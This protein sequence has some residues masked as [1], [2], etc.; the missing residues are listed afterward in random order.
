M[1]TTQIKHLLESAY[2]DFHQHRYRDKDPVMLAHAY[3][4]PEDREVAAFLAACLS[5][6]NVKTILT[7]ATRVLAVLGKSPQKALAQ[8]AFRGKFDG[9]THR[10]TKGS[11]I[12]N[13]CEWLAG[14]LEEHGS[15]HTLFTRVSA[16]K[17]MQQRLSVFLNTLTAMPLPPQLMRQRTARERN[18]KYLL[19]DPMRGSACK[20]M[21]MYL[22]WMVRADDG[23][24]LG[25]WPEVHPRD[26]M[27]PVDTHLLK[28]LR[29]LKWTRS[30]QA[31]WKVVEEATHRLRG[32]FP[33]DPI[34]YDFALCH[35]SMEGRTVRD[36]A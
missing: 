16:A 27:L 25:L 17:P 7:S 6:G 32:Y 36:Y 2:Q 15:L 35:L 1:A 12:E 24:D 34:R 31:T 10:F 3:S 18:L 8:R 21:N 26:L 5:Y 14:A 19:P 29:L 9:F 22:R 13:V 20:R 33:D 30:Q 23:I 28:T 11:D 4:R